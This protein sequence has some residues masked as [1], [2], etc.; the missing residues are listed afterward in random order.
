MG[1]L[2][3]P[4]SGICTRCQEHL[5]GDRIF[6]WSPSSWSVWC[7]NCYKEEHYPNLRRV[8]QDA[9]ECATCG[10][11]MQYGGLRHPS[12]L[13]DDTVVCTPCRERN[14]PSRNYRD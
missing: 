3:K 5:E 6:H 11:R 7:F 8:Q 1:E 9:G 2:G 13:N 10:K 12:R 4:Q 14:H